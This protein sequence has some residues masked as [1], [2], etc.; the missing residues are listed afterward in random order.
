MTDEPETFAAV[1]AGIDDYL[2]DFRFRPQ[3]NPDTPLRRL[4]AAHEREVAELNREA[5]S[6]HELYS[7]ALQDA[8]ALLADNSR[9]DATIAELKEALR[10]AHELL[11]KLWEVCDE[12]F[13]DSVSRTI[14]LARAALEKTEGGA[15]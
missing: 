7:S 5:E 6:Y 8:K 1:V 9:Q 14:D 11:K 4:V 3:A 2:R 12:T 15:K 10:S 13:E